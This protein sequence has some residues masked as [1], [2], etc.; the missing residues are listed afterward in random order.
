M[1]RVYFTEH[2]EIECLNVDTATVSSATQCN[3]DHVEVE[4]HNGVEI[5]LDSLSTLKRN[6]FVAESAQASEDTLQIELETIFSSCKK[7]MENKA[8]LA[9]KIKHA[10][11]LRKG[12]TL[13]E[14]IEEYFKGNK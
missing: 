1:E 11:W 13:E 8:Q 10:D 7:Q 5:T 14:A 3:L 4:D 12:Q 9:A 2:F 6:A